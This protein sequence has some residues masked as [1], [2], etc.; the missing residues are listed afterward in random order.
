MR[1][2]SVRRKPAVGSYNLLEFCQS[3][4]ETAAQHFSFE[5][6]VHSII[7]ASAAAVAGELFNQIDELSY[8]LPSAAVV[9][10]QYLQF[11]LDE[12]GQTAVDKNTQV[13]S[14]GIKLSVAQ[15][16]ARPSEGSPEH[17]KALRFSGCCRE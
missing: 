9:R 10:G 14:I 1:F 2:G 15:R 17:R 7:G 3:R 13:M 12:I 8:L 16:Q 11:V 6:R 5:P 4:L